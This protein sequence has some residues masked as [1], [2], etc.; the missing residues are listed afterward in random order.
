MNFIGDLL[1]PEKA[2]LHEII[3]KP[4][5]IGILR[6]ALDEKLE[7]E[8]DFEVFVPLVYYRCLQYLNDKEA[9]ILLTPPNYFISNTGK[10]VVIEDGEPREVVIV[11]SAEGY[12]RF[13]VGFGGSAGTFLPLHRALACNFVIPPGDVHPKHLQVNHINGDKEDPSLVN[14]EWCSA[15]ENMK[16]AHDEGLVVK[17]AG[18]DHYRIRPIKGTV[19]KG[20]YTGH[21]FLLVGTKEIE[22]NGFSQR[23]VSACC[24]KGRGKHLCCTFEYASEQDLTNLSRGISEDIRLDLAKYVRKPKELTS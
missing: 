14:L 16:H 3:V 1:E 8:K 6:K 19:M 24:T 7:T 11:K 23:N 9:E 17:P 21:Q 20:D 5:G 10:V 12:P 13:W 4:F 15:K 2:Y 18:L 22:E